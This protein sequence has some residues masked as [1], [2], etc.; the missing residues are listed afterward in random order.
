MG[1]LEENIVTITAEGNAVLCD[2]E[3]LYVLAAEGSE[4]VV[5]AVKQ[6]EV[7]A[8]QFVAFDRKVVVA[9][10]HVVA[11]KEQ[12]AL[13]VMGGARGIGWLV[14]SS[15]STEGAEGQDGALRHRFNFI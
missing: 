11:K 3:T 4:V 15:C 8:G 2:I 9:L 5:V 14:A 12:A 10:A 7:V 13:G 1:T 6:V